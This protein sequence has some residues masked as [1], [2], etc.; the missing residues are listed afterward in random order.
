M[1]KFGREYSETMQFSNKPNYTLYNSVLCWLWN[2]DR[3]DWGS[4]SKIQ[5][6]KGVYLTQVLAP[7]YD[8]A[9]DYVKYFSY[10]HGPYSANLQSTIHHL[11][12]LGYISLDMYEPWSKGKALYSIS[13]KGKTV[14]ADLK[15]GLMFDKIFNLTRIISNMIDIYG[16]ENIVEIV[17][18]EPTFLELKEKGITSRRILLN[19]ETNLSIKLIDHFEVLSGELFNRENVTTESLIVTYFDY[20]RASMFNEQS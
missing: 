1:R 20:L 12:C 5:M 10:K 17:Y 19:A 4:Q 15:K 6:Q 13:K 2:V 9:E 14:I 11:C 3:L 18:Q 7:L 8:L 16:I